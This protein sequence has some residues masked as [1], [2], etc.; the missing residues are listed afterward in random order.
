MNSLRILGIYVKE[1]FVDGVQL[2]YLLSKYGGVIR[3][4]LGL[5]EVV[6]DHARP[7]GLIIL[8]LNGDLSEIQRLENE[9]FAIDSLEIQKMNFSK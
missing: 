2:Q 3:T 6:E 9:L 4:R 1:G 7:G 5:H 8:E